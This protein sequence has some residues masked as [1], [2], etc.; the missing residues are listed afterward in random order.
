MQTFKCQFQ[1]PQQ[2]GKYPFV[3]HLVCDSYVGMDAKMEVVL[4]VEDQAK[5]EVMAE[6]DEISEPDEGTYSIRPF[7]PCSGASTRFMVF[8]C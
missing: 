2:V 8:P 7:S 3:M 5:A 6:E 1:A 4:D